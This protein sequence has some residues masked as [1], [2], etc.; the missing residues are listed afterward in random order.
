[1]KNL[2]VLAALLLNF[3][4]LSAQKEPASATGDQ[5]KEKKLLPAQLDTVKQKASKAAFKSNMAEFRK[6]FVDE[7]RDQ[8]TL[9][10]MFYNVENLFDT[11]NDP[12][13]ADE[14][15]ARAGVVSRQITLR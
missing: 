11:I 1:M 5:P 12:L 10:V 2:L 9:R 6:F 8:N 15:R 13:T 3:S 7:Q 14:R 4:Y